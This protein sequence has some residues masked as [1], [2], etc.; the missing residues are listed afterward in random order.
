LSGIDAVNPANER[1]EV[2]KMKRRFVCSA[3]ASMLAMPV[4]ALSAGMDHGGMPGM[5]MEGHAGMPAKPGMHDVKN[6]EKIFAGSVGPWTCEAR[7]VDMRAQ[8]EASGVSAKTAARFAGR[9]HLMLFLTDTA[10]GKAAAG[11]SG[12]VVVTGP[13]G[14]SSSKA[15]LV[16]MGGHIGVD[17]GTPT[18]G[19]YTF[20]ARIEADG[21]RGS[22]T[23]S[24]TVK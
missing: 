16:A 1:N 17:V 5:K 13:D 11:V 14:A 2:M 10:T 23:F 19:K 18:P 7:L 4:M 3:M 9:R 12:E 21:K 24:Y 15:A 20:N 8:M 22:A 6:G